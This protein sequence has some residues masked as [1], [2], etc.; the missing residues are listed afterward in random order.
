MELSIKEE[1]R[2]DREDTWR[3]GIEY[4]LG[5]FAE[6]VNH[7]AV[8]NHAYFRD[9]NG[10]LYTIKQRVQRLLWGD[11]AKVILL[12]LILWRVW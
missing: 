1:I 3:D 9:F 2:R 11:V 4:N 12:V 10:A 5:E 8:E 6:A 7:H